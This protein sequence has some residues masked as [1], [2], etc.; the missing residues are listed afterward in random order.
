MSIKKVYKWGY[1]RKHISRKAE[2]VS[3]LEFEKTISPDKDWEKPK[4][5]DV[6][7]CSPKITKIFDYNQMVAE[8]L[9][10]SPI[11][12]PEL[13][14]SQSECKGNPR[15]AEII[16]GSWPL[17]ASENNEDPI[18]YDHY[19]NNEANE[20]RQ[21]KDFELINEEFKEEIVDHPNFTEAED[22]IN[23][24]WNSNKNIWCLP[25]FDNNILKMDNEFWIS[26]NL[27]CFEKVWMHNNLNDSIQT[28]EMHSNQMGEL[29]YSRNNPK[30][31]FQELADSGASESELF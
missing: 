1:D 18:I 20:N 11:E 19:K 28:L 4:R 17:V 15:S 23:S 29:T 2:L 3:S 25:S 6:N 13:N 24:I 8:I 26:E 9:S 30:F 14:E 7:L 21:T 10:N 31:L 5:D 22:S 27:E 12:D 16:S